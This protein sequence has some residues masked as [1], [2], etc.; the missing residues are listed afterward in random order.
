[1]AR[2]RTWIEHEERRWLLP[3]VIVHPARSPEVDLGR[4]VEHVGPRSVENGLVTAPARGPEDRS[5]PGQGSRDRRRRRGVEAHPRTSSHSSSAAVTSVITRYSIVAS[6]PARYPQGSCSSGRCKWS[7]AIA[8]RI[9]CDFRASAREDRAE[10][11]L[12][13]VAAAADSY[14]GSAVTFTG[15]FDAIPRP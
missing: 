12:L 15:S 11:E 7:V 1:M 10:R 6:R 14:S 2:V 13:T 8:L 4:F 9:R 5:I 3:P